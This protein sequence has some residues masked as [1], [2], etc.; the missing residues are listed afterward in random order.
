[1][2]A[3]SV[4]ESVS[5]VEVHICAALHEFQGQEGELSFTVTIRAAYCFILYRNDLRRV[6]FH[7]LR[8]GFAPS[9]LFHLLRSG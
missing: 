2:F 3:E 1:M 4:G 9:I 7:Y 8:L 6:V 5:V